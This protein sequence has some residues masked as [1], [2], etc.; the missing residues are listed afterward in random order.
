MKYRLFLIILL[1][2]ASITGFSKE[3][4]KVTESELSAY[5]NSCK[6]FNMEKITLTGDS[7]RTDYCTNAD[8]TSYISWIFD[9]QTIKSITLKNDEEYFF[10]HFEC[11]DK[12]CI[13]I[14]V[15][16]TVYSPKSE[17]DMYIKSKEEA[18]KLLEMLM[19]Y[20]NRKMNH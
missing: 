15:I 2:A 4:K 18:K 7:I 20:K 1:F 9:L 14:P 5:I 13:K 12:D 8:C 10:L 11:N 6:Q 3:N 16:G 17:Y 19:N